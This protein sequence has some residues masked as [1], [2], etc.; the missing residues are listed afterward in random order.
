MSDRTPLSAKPLIAV[1]AQAA[2]EQPR[3]INRSVSQSGLV[4]RTGLC[5]GSGGSRCV[6]TPDGTVRCSSIRSV[7]AGA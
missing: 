4:R 1:Q 7:L 2:V 6:S 5:S 3:A